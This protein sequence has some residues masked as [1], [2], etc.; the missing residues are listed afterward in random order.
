MVSQELI[1]FSLFGVIIMGIVPFIAGIVLIKMQK[2]WGSNFTA[3]LITAGVVVIVNKIISVVISLLFPSSEENA[4]FFTEK[5]VP[6]SVVIMILS[7][8]ITALLMCVCV[9]ICSEKKFNMKEAASCGLGLGVGYLMSSAFNLLV[10]RQ[11]LIQIENGGFDLK[12]YEAIAKG[13]LDQKTIDLTKLAYTSITFEDMLS[14]VIFSFGVSM[15]CVACGILIMRGIYAKKLKS[16]VAVSAVTIAAAG[17]IYCVVPSIVIGSVISAVIG[18]A[19][20]ILSIKTKIGEN[21]NT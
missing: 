18:I 3:G 1:D 4:F 7:G 6:A 19:V 20:L 5:S 10:I 8:V 11:N 9:S 21:N 13:Y 2:L 14:Q 15:L 16:G 17:V 12:G